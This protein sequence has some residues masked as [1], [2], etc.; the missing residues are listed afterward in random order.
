MNKPMN[1]LDLPILS[2]SARIFF[3]NSTTMPWWLGI[4]AYD[5]SVFMVT[6]NVPAFL[7]Q[8]IFG[9]EA[10]LHD[11]KTTQWYVRNWRHHYCFVATVYAE[12]CCFRNEIQKRLA[13]TAHTPKQCKC[14]YW[15]L[16]KDQRR[17]LSPYAAGQQ[18]CQK[19]KGSQWLSPILN[20]SAYKAK[21][22]LTS[23]RKQ[24]TDLLS[25]NWS[26]TIPTM[27][28]LEA[29]SSVGHTPEY[30]ELKLISASLGEVTAV[31]NKNNKQIIT[32]FYCIW[33]F[34][35]LLWLVYM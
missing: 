5:S 17:A 4:W 9:S 24:K 3:L 33:G 29:G 19:G 11:C 26:L 25:S 15:H 23:N 14:I 30:F 10:R 8:S 6:V 1:V 28:S 35:F 2:I 16:K 27:M 7:W 31:R 21:I 20:L 32:W 12:K 22:L 18:K 34:S 13:L